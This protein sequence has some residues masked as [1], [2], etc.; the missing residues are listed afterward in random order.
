MLRSTFIAFASISDPR[1]PFRIIA[2]LSVIIQCIV[3]VGIVVKCQFTNKHVIS[4]HD[5][6][7]IT[8]TLQH[9]T[10]AP[11][12]QSLTQQQSR[13]GGGSDKPRNP[14]KCPHCKK[15]GGNGW[16]HD[17]PK[18]VSH[19]DCQFNKKYKGWKP[20]WVIAKMAKQDKADKD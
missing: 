15:Y 4:N 16:A 17:E 2:V 11:R 1:F 3:I 19:D 18:K 8:L 14:T 9:T 6:T 12:P 10:Q 7:L 5:I 20:D 13:Q